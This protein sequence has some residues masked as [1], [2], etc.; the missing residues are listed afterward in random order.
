[1]YRIFNIITVI[2]ILGL[3]SACGIKGKI[4]T[5]SNSQLNRSYP[6]E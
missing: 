3:I 6:Y 5:P 2:S 1:M 4:L